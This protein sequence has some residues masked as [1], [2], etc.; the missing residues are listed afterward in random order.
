VGS[1]QTYID[2]RKA[3]GSGAFLALAALG[4]SQS[5]TA[6]SVQD[7]SNP[8]VL[9]NQG[10][11][12]ALLQAALPLGPIIDP[13][14]IIALLRGAP[15]ASAEIALTAGGFAL[16]QIGAPGFGGVTGVTLSVPASPVSVPTGNDVTFTPV[17]L[18]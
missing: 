4:F 16:V 6:V 3:L 9:A 12:L 5:V 1:V 8:N 2:K 11:A 10:A 13:A 18:S 14:L 17:S 15:V 7:G